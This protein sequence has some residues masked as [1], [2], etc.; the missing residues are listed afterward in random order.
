[1]AIKSIKLFV[2]QRNAHLDAPVTV[3]VLLLMFLWTIM[4]DFRPKIYDKIGVKIHIRPP[5]FGWKKF[6]CKIPIFEFLLILQIYFDFKIMQSEGLFYS[7]RK[8]CIL[9][10]KYKLLNCFIFQNTTVLKYAYWQSDRTCKTLS[11]FWASYIWPN[12]KRGSNGP[13]NIKILGRPGVGGAVNQRYLIFFW[14]E[15]LKPGSL[16]F[17]SQHF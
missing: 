17:F 15:I 7:Y 3:D 2:C 10:V 6:K 4:P 9:R 12:K 8:M 5:E 11:D 14:W 13:K 1:M 16:V